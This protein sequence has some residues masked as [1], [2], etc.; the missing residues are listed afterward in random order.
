M[1]PSYSH[2][3]KNKIEKLRKEMIQIGLEEGLRNKRTIEISQ[4]LDFYITIYQYL[5]KN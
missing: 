2:H 1:E 4:K 5:M 3:L